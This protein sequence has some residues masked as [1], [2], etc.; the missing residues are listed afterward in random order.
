M[1]NPLYSMTKEQLINYIG[2][3]EEIIEKYD[4]KLNKLYKK[5][6]EIAGEFNE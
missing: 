1:N 2:K 3:L 4:V 5:S 6:M